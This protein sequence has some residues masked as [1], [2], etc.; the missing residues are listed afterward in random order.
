MIL[1]HQRQVVDAVSG[2]L[3]PCLRCSLRLPGVP[4][5]C[6]LRRCGLLR[7][8]L[9]GL[10]RLCLRR[11]LRLFRLFASAGC[12]SKCHADCKQQTGLLHILCS[13]FRFF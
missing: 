6:G 13:L 9:R 1:V 7:L 11:S 10:L 8:C 5:L 4:G 3:R 12:K 2:L